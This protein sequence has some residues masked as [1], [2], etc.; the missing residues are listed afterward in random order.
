MICK[1]ADDSQRFILEHIDIISNCP[2]EIYHYALPFSPSS[3]WLREYYSPELLQRVKV[4]KGLQAKWGRC[5]RTVSLDS[6]SWALAYWKDLVSVGLCSGDIAILD[7]ITGI[8]ISVLSSHT[9][10]VASLVFSLDGVFLVSGSHDKNVILWDI[11]TGGVIKTFYGHTSYVC[12]VSISPDYTTIASGSQDHTIRLW[13]TQRGECHCVI[14]GHNDG[15]YSVSFPPTNSKLLISASEDGTVRQWDIDGHQIGSTYGGNEVVFSSDGTCLISWK[16][17]GRVATVWNFNSWTVMAEIQ[18]PGG[19]LECCCFSPD[20]KFVAGNIN[21]TIYIWNITGS[22][23]C[24][25][26]TLSE[27]TSSICSLVFSSSLIS[28]FR[29]GSVRFWQTGTSSVDLVAT[30]LRSTPHA[31]AKIRSVSIQA[32]DGIVISSDDAGV[33]KTWDILTGL[34]KASFQIPSED[35][36]Y[37]DA[38][39]IGGRLTIVWLEGDEYDGWEIQVWDLEKGESLQ[40]LEIESL[41]PL[42]VESAEKPRDFRI[43]AD[44]SR[45]FLLHE[46][47]IQARSISTGQVVGEVTLEGEPLNDS[48]IVDRSSVWVCFKDLQTQGWD[49]GLPG[50]VPVPLSNSPLDRPHLW[51]IGTKDQ[52]ISPSR[53]EDMVTG[54]VVFQPPGRYATPCVV[55]LDGQYLV[56]GYETGEVLILDLNQTTPQ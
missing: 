10:R 43:S 51:F 23:P 45:V 42:D 55:Q 14:Y 8:C 33:V 49:F 46:K 39:F 56:A 40:T 24:L 21:D 27:H 17:H 35:P 2:S 41:Q 36:I 4:V 34:C 44:G 11:Q 19:S 15:V 26:E 9:N 12:S 20:G 38:Q 28:S 52:S 37:R 5:Y 48:L 7:G 6:I 13:D 31:S 50:S 25:V 30:S 54:K 47:C 22:A 18:L 29:D 16:W 3:S 32:N 53:I 1:W